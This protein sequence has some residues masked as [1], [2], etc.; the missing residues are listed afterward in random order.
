MAHG[1]NI[2]NKMKDKA[3]IIDILY[4][5][6]IFNK[7]HGTWKEYESVIIEKYKSH[8]FIVCMGYNSLFGK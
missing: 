3:W 2:F 4:L 6:G 7:Y 1:K 8:I 5:N